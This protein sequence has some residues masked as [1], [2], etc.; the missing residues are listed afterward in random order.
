MQFYYEVY[1][2]LRKQKRN[3]KRLGVDGGW[4]RSSATFV[5]FFGLRFLTQF[6]QTLRSIKI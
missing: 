6:N 4:V 2:G 1:L 5:S 3:Q